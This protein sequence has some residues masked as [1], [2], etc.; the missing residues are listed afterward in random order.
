MAKKSVGDIKLQVPAGKA[1]PGQSIGPAL[2]QKGLN[3][4]EFCKAFNAKTQSM[5]PGMPLPVL[6]TAYTDRSFT[7]IIKQPPTSY[8]I[9]EALGLT[10][11]SSATGRDKSVARITHAQIEE[12]A[13]KK[14]EDMNAY[15]KE[16]ACRM[17]RGSALSM[18]IEVGEKV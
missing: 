8:F 14:M 16:A 1:T 7:F 13:E 15:T 4:M 6:I 12:I 11:G 9:K 10:K 2:S 17:V 3:I 5:K 18:G